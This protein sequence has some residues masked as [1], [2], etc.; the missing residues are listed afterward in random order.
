M[1]TFL[2]SVSGVLGLFFFWG[3]VS[4]RSQWHVLVG[5]TRADPRSSEPGSAAYATTRFVSLL[6]LLSVLAIAVS[7]GVGVISFDEDGDEAVRQPSVAERVWG[8][9]RPYIVDRVFTPLAAPPEGL[10]EQQVTG[11]QRVR[12]YER[13]PNYLFAAGKI[14]AAGLATEPGFLGVVPL[15]G[16]VALGM[17]DLVVHVRGDSR[18]IPQQVVVTPVDDAVQVG[19]FFG[20]P[21][22]ADGSN[23][24]NLGECDPA[25]AASDT[26]GFIIPI[27]L[28][29]P[30]GDRVVQTLAVEPIAL[31]PLPA[32]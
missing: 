13:S 3:L 14:R 28:V 21:N 29:E 2:I 10:V 22:P 19:V 16:T 27:D 18:C 25:P 17:A 26:R 30:L 8:S 20:L 5:W 9:P 6:G 24:D 31:V 15:P 4:P 12:G 32:R 23:A 1:N 11:Y 7:W